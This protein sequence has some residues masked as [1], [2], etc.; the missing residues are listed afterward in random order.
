VIVVSNATPLI[1]MAAVGQFDLLSR[2]F[3]E[4]TI[5]EEVWT[6]VVVQGAGRFGALETSQANWIQVVP[7]ADSVLLSAWKSTCNLAAGELSTILLAKELSATVV[8]IDER[9]ARSLA[10][11]EGLV[12]SGSI[13]LLESGYRKKYVSDLRQV[14]TQL[15][16][17]NI[18]VA[19]KML[20]KSLTKFGLP[21][22]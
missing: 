16:A 11:R 13:A 20:N 9:K 5:S 18:R 8:L 2:L 4:I 6:E 21:P 10:A 15:L 19:E 12:L 14:Y 7:L 1:T 3:T 22:L 17:A